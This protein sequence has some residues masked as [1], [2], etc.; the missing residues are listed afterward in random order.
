VP[1]TTTKTES[2]AHRQYKREI[3]AW[4]QERLQAA[5]VAADRFVFEHSPEE[6]ADALFDLHRADIERHVLGLLTTRH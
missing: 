5:R 2:R 4:K 1:P 3:E 6:V